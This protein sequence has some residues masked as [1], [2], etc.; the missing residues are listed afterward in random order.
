MFHFATTSVVKML[1]VLSYGYIAYQLGK[2]SK[3]GQIEKHGFDDYEKMK[4]RCRDK[5]I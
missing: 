4:T 1:M 3:P 5:G 2:V